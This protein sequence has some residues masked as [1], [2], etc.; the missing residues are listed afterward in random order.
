MTIK[1][2]LYIIDGAGILNYDIEAKN[3]HFRS[4]FPRK[5]FFYCTWHSCIP[6]FLK[7]L[8]PIPHVTVLF[9]GVLNPDILLDPDIIGLV[10]PYPDLVKTNGP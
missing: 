5:I 6:C 8:S 1:I 2:I 7:N 4:F 9:Y 10:D 3:M